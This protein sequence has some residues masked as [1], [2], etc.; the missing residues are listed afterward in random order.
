M[1]QVDL[2]D[3]SYALGATEI[4]RNVSLTI[5]E[6]EC[7]ALLGP[8]GCGKTTTLRCI[9]GFVVPT[10]GNVRIGGKSV[11]DL[12]PNQRN[13][14]LVFQD[15]ALFPHM[16]VRQNIAY[17]LE[18]RK[19]GK[20]EL[21]KRVGEMVAIT[22][23]DGLEER[24]PDQLSGGQ[25]QRV[26][27]ARA[28]VIEPD[29]LLLDEPLGAL[30]R[31]LREEMQVELKRI[32]RDLGITTVFVTHDQEEALSLSDRIAVM[33]DGRIVETGSPERLYHAPQ[34]RGV[35]S[36][37]GTSNIWQA[38]VEAADGPYLQL[39]SGDIRVRVAAETRLA[40]G[41]T[42][43]VGIRPEHI[44]ISAEPPEDAVNIVPGRIETTVYKG[45]HVEV[46]VG[47]AAGIEFLARQPAV[48]TE[49]GGGLRS[50]DPV[51]LSFEP[52]NVLLFPSES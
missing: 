34:Q 35:M 43:Q 7:L 27:L 48:S 6:G 45:A 11:V 25:R 39:S 28:L 15:Y 38:T 50:G 33:F 16:S 51:Y 41:A 4:L 44:R 14:G 3:V 8:S 46:Y 47:T 36:F 26:A 52:G 23:L 17:G 29:V 10:H 32:Q 37:L 19:V 9:A 24:R 20:A 2:E 1:A 31:L 49:S 18:R 12:R 13:V 30:D 22:H 21:A 40:A 42:A 5:G